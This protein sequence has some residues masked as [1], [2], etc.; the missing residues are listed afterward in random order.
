[1]ALLRKQLE[2]P[3]EVAK[4]FVRDMRAFHRE[5]SQIKRAEIAARQRFAL[6]Q[7]QGPRDK[8]LRVTEVIKMFNEMKAKPAGAHL[9]GTVPSAGTPGRHG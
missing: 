9:V 2:L 5:K 7:F 6:S 3:P 8:T 1:M 4:A